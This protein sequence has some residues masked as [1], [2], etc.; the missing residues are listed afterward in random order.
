MQTSLDLGE[1][2]ARLRYFCG[3]SFGM[4]LGDQLDW[5]SGVVT[6]PRYIDRCISECELPIIIDN[7]AFP[8]WRKGEPL[9]LDDQLS[10]IWECVEKSGERCRF[11]IAPDVIGDARKTWVRIA[12]S[13]SELRSLW[14]RLLLPMQ[15]GVDTARFV[16]LAQRIGAG[17]FIGG[18][19]KQW[20]RLRIDA[21][22]A[23]DAQSERQKENPTE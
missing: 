17:L 6:T 20:K 11:V 4:H 21:L 14:S 2:T 9:T 7:G 15:E 5:C 19:S 1:P 22:A 8:A 12:A 18:S 16:S 13:L 3:Y 23:L 10:G